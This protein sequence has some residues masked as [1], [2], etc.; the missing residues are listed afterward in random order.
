MDKWIISVDTT[1]DIPESYL[2]EHNILEQPLHYIVEGKE[3]GK[4]IEELPIKEF[5]AKIRAGVMPTTSAT[6]I[7]FVRKQMEDAVKDGYAILHLPFSAAMSASCSNAF[8]AKNMLEEVYPDAKIEIVDILSATCGV[9]ALVM[10]L[11]EMKDNGAS[12]EEAVE[13]AKSYVGKARV[14][15]TV[16][17]LMHLYRGGRLKKSSAVVATIVG[18]NPLLKVNPE[19]KL[20]TFDKVRGRKKALAYLADGIKNCK[21]F[22]KI[23]TI[24]I[25]HG[26][27]E[28]EANALADKIKELYPN[29][30]T[31]SVNYLSQTLGS[32]TGAGAMVVGYLSGEN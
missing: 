10:K 21:D 29:I 7:D 16:Q 5:Y 20:E 32:H 3:Y 9:F 30:K 2:K 11:V 23:D 28:E 27:C 12:F 22:E 8:L 13:F 31:V 6:N 1:A 18:I 26:D 4:D 14:W 24:S 25:A 19:G 15:F 17:D